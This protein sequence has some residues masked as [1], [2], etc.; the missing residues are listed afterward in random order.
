MPSHLVEIDLLL[1]IIHV[2]NT[3][4]SKMDQINSNREKVANIDFLDAQ[5]QPS[6]WAVVGSDQISNSSK[7]LCIPTLPARMKK[8]LIKNS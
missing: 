7:L 6:L 2:L 5:G 8:D 1:D 3:Y 4:K